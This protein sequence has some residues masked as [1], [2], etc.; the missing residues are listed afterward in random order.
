MPSSSSSSSSSSPEPEPETEPE[1]DACSEDADGSS[2][3]TTTS[4]SSSSSRVRF[5]MV[6]ACRENES[7][8]QVH[9]VMA[10]KR[11]RAQ[12][13][14]KKSNLAGVFLFLRTGIAANER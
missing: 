13:W 11:A 4:S 8:Q 5:G 1:P 9:V 7:P 3:G 2:G 10:Q 14:P 12:N 6:V